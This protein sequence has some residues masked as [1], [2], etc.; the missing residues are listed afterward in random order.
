MF[1]SL[2]SIASVVTIFMYLT[3][4]KFKQV[5]RSRKSL[6]KVSTTTLQEAAASGTWDW[7]KQGFADLWF[8]DILQ[9]SLCLLKEVA[10][11]GKKEVACI[12]SKHLA[13]CLWGC[14][15]SVN[16]PK[17]NIQE[18]QGGICP[19]NQSE[20]QTRDPIF[21]FVLLSDH[22]PDLEWIGTEKAGV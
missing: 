16:P 21:M 11:K 13:S 20:T 1:K 4:S 2:D 10:T 9:I 7:T 12:V 3:I 6:G 18:V 17:L 5:L 15:E 19:R 8:P 14:G 22:T